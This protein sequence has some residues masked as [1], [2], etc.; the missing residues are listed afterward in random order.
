MENSI[1]Q[2]ISILNNNDFKAKSKKF[3]EDI[4]NRD[5]L[6]AE[7]HEM[8]LPD[9]IIYYELN[10]FTRAI[11]FSDYLVKSFK[12]FKRAFLTSDIRLLFYSFSMYSEISFAIF[13]IL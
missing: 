7:R 8:G 4:D 3:P 12:K 13:R 10:G 1:D 9:Y 6:M 2:F 5:E 11:E